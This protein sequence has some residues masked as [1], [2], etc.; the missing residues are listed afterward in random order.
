M[1]CFIFWWL[2]G[3]F[4]LSLGYYLYE[5]YIEKSKWLGLWVI[6]GKSFLIGSFSWFGIVMFI[7]IEI[8]YGI[9]FLD[10]WLENKI[11]K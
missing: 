6:A 4:L 9:G 1:W 10:E 7:A 8:I 5:I 11:R 2:V 3:W